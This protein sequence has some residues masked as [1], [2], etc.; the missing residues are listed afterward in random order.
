MTGMRPGLILRVVLSAVALFLVVRLVSGRDLVAALREA[1][2]WPLLVSIGC[3][4][5][6]RVVMAFKWGILLCA[7]GIVRP[8]RELVRI[9]LVGTFYGSFLPT[10]VGGDVIRVLEVARGRD[11]IAA[12]TAS[13]VME[14]VLGLIALVLVVFGCLV[15]FAARE[16]GRFG[17]L[18]LPVAIMFIAGVLGLAWA[19][20]GRL[21][22]RLERFAAA[23]RRYAGERPAL[24]QF[25]ALS[26]VE[27]LLPVAANY[28]MSRAL[29]L[30]VSFLTFLLIIPIILF[31]A[32]IPIS[33]DGLGL[34]EGLYVW[35]FAYAGLGPSESFLLALMG[36]VFTVLASLPGMF[37][38]KQKSA[39]AD[40]AAARA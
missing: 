37:L 21:P 14:R 30:E 40:P 33:I 18:L 23:F 1:Q 7:I 8:L 22:R 20:H 16:G 39:N 11:E 32:R 15:A 12:V 2:P 3:M 26:L 28:W 4:L 27:Q 38:R 17:Q 13:V 35:L 25:F 19:L 5:L 31:V 9:Y 29:G 10:G 34:V 36:R 6:D 24:G